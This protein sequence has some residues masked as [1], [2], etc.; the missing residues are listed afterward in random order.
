M[1]S[2]TNDE[3]AQILRYLRYP[4]WQALAQSFQLGYPSEAQEEFLV[5]SSFDRI[6]DD[7]LEYIR[8]DLCEL[9]SIENQRSEARSRFKAS[10]IGDI[11]IDPQKELDLLSREYD[12]WTGQLRDDLG[13]EMNP[14]SSVERKGA[15]MGGMNARVINH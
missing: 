3:K 4:N 2:L 8:R 12:Y 7:S 1:A 11:K 14:W 13:V 9:R 6:S 10:Q 15:G 5:R